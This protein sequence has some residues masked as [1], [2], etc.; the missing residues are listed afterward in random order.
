MYCIS[1]EKDI[2]HG[3]FKKTEEGVMV[4]CLDC[5]LQYDQYRKIKAKWKYDHDAIY[6]MYQKGYSFK[7]IATYHGTNPLTVG[8]IIR[9]KEKNG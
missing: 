4:I 3:Y 9:E 1:C 6:E 8:H 5:L 7:S 2:D